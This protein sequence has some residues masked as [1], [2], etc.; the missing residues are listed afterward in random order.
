MRADRSRRAQMLLTGWDNPLRYMQVPSK[1]TALP[2][3]KKNSG[4]RSA[5]SGS[6]RP[7]LEAGHDP[8]ALRGLAVTGKRVRRRLG[9]PA[10]LLAG[11]D[12]R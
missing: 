7:R 10:A 11:A 1:W 2:G 9:H 3:V 8:H 4:T 5:T 12:S 6:V